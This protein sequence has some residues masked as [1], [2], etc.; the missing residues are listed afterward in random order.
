MAALTLLRSGHPLAD[1]REQ[2]AQLDRANSGPAFATRVAQVQGAPL[3]AR[4][5]EVLQVNV[6]RVCNQTCRH[7][8]VDAGPDRTEAMSGDVADACL[9]LLARG[10]FT[11][12]DITGGAPEMN[13]QFRRLVERGHA[14]GKQVLDRCNLTILEAPGY[15]DLAG[16]LARHQVEV[17]ASLPCYLGQN[18]DR[19]RG[20]RV[21]DRSLAALRRLN[22]LGYGQ[23]GSG[24][25]LT[26]VF[27]PGGPSLPPPQQKLEADY[28]RELRARYGIE[29]TRLFTI[30]NMPISRFLEDLLSQGRLEE[31]LQKLVHAFNPATVDAVMCRSTLSV[32]W[33]G[34]LFDCDF[35]QMLD[36]PVI[37][38]SPASVFD[39]SEGRIDQLAGRM[40]ATANHCYGCTAGTGSSCGGSLG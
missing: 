20:D 7:C 2:L 9:D 37:G 19:Q 25:T 10:P 14:L 29:F 32:D 30:T 34:R 16:F 5:L 40:I 23:P 8:H 35:N 4:T 38:D 6:G 31:Y 39:L 21:F 11:T 15:G 33:Q 36:L 12:L 22:A 18:V 1:P 24:L 27:N 13:P 3:R 17:I 26:L 28:R